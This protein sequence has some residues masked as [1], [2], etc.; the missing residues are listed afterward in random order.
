MASSRAPRASLRDRARPARSGQ[1]PRR[2]RRIRRRARLRPAAGLRRSG[3]RWPSPT[4]REPSS[5]PARLRRRMPDSGGDQAALAGR[6]RLHELLH[7]RPGTGPLPRGP[8]SRARRRRAPFFAGCWGIFGH[9]NVA[10]IGQA[11]QQYSEVPLLPGRNE[12]A[13]VHTAAGYAKMKNRFGRSPAPRRLARARPTWSQARRWRRSTVFRCCCSPA[14]FSRSDASPVLQQLEWE[15]SR[16][17]GQ[18]RFGPSRA[19]GIAS[20]D[21]SRS[22]R[23]CRKRCA[24]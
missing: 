2:R 8:V 7:R 15:H 6:G 10:G 24:C 1:R 20:T 14:T 22:S 3:P 23:R 21:R 19:T 16:I 11:L 4:P 5:P 12:Q 18:R 9:G 13:M 17:F